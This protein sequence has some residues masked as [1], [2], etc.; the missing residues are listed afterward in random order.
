MCPAQPLFCAP[1]MNKLSDFTSD[2]CHHIDQSLV[3]FETSER[4][5]LQH[6]EKRATALDGKGNAALQ[7]RATSDSS[8]HTG[9]V[10]LNICHPNESALLPDAPW[11]AGPPCKA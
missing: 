7:S 8:S 3:M 2:C 1:A 5:E 9:R 6:P 11:K 10:T 4:K